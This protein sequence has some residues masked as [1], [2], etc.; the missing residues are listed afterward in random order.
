MGIDYSCSLVYGV[1]LDE[2]DVHAIFQKSEKVEGTFHME[3]RFDPKTG[4][5]MKQEKVWDKKPETHTWYEID[6]KKYDDLDPEEWES[7]LEKK[8]GCHVDTSGSFPSGELTYVF[9]V[10]EPISWKK[11]D[12]Y[13]KVTVY[14]NVMEQ[15]DIPGL[16]TKALLLSQRMEEFGLGKHTPRIFI[17][18]RIS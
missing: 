5:K 6:G 3:D 1:E 16:I 10:N 12:D 13:G 9:Y 11:A 18:T 8:L 2:K 15:K 17:A 14:N 4:A 7:I